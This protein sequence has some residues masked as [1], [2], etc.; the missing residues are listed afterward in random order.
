MCW[1]GPCR[2]LHPL[3]VH[4]CISM[5][6]KAKCKQFQAYVEAGWK[7][8]LKWYDIVWFLF[9]ALFYQCRLAFLQGSWCS[10]QEC[11]F[12]M[13]SQCTHPFC[14][15]NGQ[16]HEGPENCD[17]PGSLFNFVSKEW[18]N[19]EFLKLRLH[20]GNKTGAFTTPKSRGE[21]W[22]KKSIPP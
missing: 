18:T 11:P 14:S 21:I 5:D 20:L 8:S 12:V 4:I 10:Y 22:K 13:F 9:Y 2:L 1:G 6:R 19:G 17:D 7:A 16:G 15:C 3:F